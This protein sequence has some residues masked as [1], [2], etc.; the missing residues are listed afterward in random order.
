[1]GLDTVAHY[2]DETTEAHESKKIDNKIL[3]EFESI[4]ELWKIGS[5]K[6]RH[7]GLV[8]RILTGD[9][10]DQFMS[11]LRVKEVAKIYEEF[12]DYYCVT[13]SEY[14]NVAFDIKNIDEEFI[15]DDLEDYY[16]RI[17]CHGYPYLSTILKLSK[18]FDVCMKYNLC[19][20]SDW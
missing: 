1:M 3:A 10:I 7:H 5:F 18:F 17:S 6:P 9:D 20:K 4:E 14:E 15:R 19:L 2:Y 11:P 13:K 8:F 16:D 12:V